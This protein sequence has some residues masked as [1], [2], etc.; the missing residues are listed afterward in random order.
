[1]AQFALPSNSKVTKGKTH[2]LKEPAKNR[3][4]CY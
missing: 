3:L 2:Q 4:L 1:M